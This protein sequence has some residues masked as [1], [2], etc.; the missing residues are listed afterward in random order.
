M[1][2]HLALRSLSMTVLVPGG[3]CWRTEPSARVALLMDNE[4][5][6]AAL[7]SA[8]LLLVASVVFQRRDLE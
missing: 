3:T 8:G 7:Y 4:P 6:Y 2:S 1:P 5:Y